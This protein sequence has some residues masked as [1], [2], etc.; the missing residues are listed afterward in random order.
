[1]EDLDLLLQAI[2][3]ALLLP[4]SDEFSEAAFLPNTPRQSE[5]AE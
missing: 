5:R 1:L 3:Y 4:R 2:D